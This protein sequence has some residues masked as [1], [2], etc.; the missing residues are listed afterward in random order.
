MKLLFTATG[1][2][3][4]FALKDNHLNFSTSFD[5]KIQRINLNL[6]TVVIK[7]VLR[8]HV[9]VSEIALSA[10]EFYFCKSNADKISKITKRDLFPK[11]G[12]RRCF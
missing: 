1:G 2:L 3:N 6:Q 8:G 12:K 5:G 11:T 7:T 10:D 4:G 9:R